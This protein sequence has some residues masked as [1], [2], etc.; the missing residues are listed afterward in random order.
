MDVVGRVRIVD[1][2]GMNLPVVL[3]RMGLGLLTSVALAGC[4][5]QVPASS[6]PQE[7]DPAGPGDEEQLRPGE[8]ANTYVGHGDEEGA[9][10][11]DDDADDEADDEDTERSASGDAPKSADDGRLDA[12]ELLALANAALDEVL[13]PY[14]ARVVTPLLPTEW[15]STSGTV[16]VLAYPLTPLE[17]GVTRY[18]LSSPSY[19]VTLAV[20]DGTVTTESLGKKAKRLGTIEKA[21]E[22]SDDPIHQGEQALVDVVAGRKTPEKASRILR[23]YIE[24]ADGHGAVGKDAEARAAAFF[25]ALR[26]Q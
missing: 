20:G 4:G 12:V 21:R 23:H 8:V 9:E 14:A 19:R 26:G 7:S 11:G 2:R 15:P 10:D 18:T 25:K 16:M 13:D 6:P 17:S 1:T 3:L 22:R 5:K 24:W